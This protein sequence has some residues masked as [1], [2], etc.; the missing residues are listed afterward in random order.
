MS[1]P[2]PS[3]AEAARCEPMKGYP[4][5]AMGK[6]LLD[7]GRLDEAVAT[8]SKAVELDPDFAQAHISLGRALM[9]KGEF[10]AAL[11]VVPTV[12]RGS[13]APRFRSPSVELVREA[14]RMIA[15]TIDFPNSCE[16]S[17][18]Q[19]DVRTD[20][21]RPP[22]PD[23]RALCDFGKLWEKA[24]AASRGCRRA[25]RREPIRRRLR[26]GES[27]CRRRQGKS[28]ARSGHARAFATEGPRMARSRTRGVTGLMEKDR[29]AIA[30][31]RH[32]GSAVAG[33]D[34]AGRSTRRGEPR[35]AHNE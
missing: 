29:P 3:F 4:H 32:R 31:Q 30:R 13:P 16:E 10:E 18:S 8:L 20:P 33:R 2:W 21:P 35:S 9:A 34:A 22:L 25:E 12:Q 5:E 15:L 1:P 6:I 26:G 23:Q 14:E 27:G 24:F 7:V 17:T 28:A 19:P 11:C